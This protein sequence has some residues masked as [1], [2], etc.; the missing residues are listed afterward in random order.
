M[1]RPAGAP[2]P[3]PSKETTA[4]TEARLAAILAALPLERF[5][6]DK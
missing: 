3:K 5:D 4:R 2:L 6:K 1:L